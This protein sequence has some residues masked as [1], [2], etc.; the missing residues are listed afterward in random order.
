MTSIKSIGRPKGSQVSAGRQWTLGVEI[1][2]S[3][4]GHK[5][6]YLQL[7]VFRMVSIAADLVKLLRWSNSSQFSLARPKMGTCI[8]PPSRSGIQMLGYRYIGLT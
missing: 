3:V 4:G 8:G 7:R 1:D 6:L 2:M 5:W